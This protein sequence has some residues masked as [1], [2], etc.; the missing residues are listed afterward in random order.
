MEG[1]D[2]QLALV[3]L[4]TRNW[5]IRTPNESIFLHS[6]PSLWGKSNE[7]PG[8]APNYHPNSFHGPLEDK[9]VEPLPS[10]ASGPVA[11][12]ATKDEDNFGQ[13]AIFWAKVLNYV[14]FQGSHKAGTLLCCS[15][16]ER[17]LVEH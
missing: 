8:G 16:N 1:F 13:A 7:L 2:H 6:I 10:P 15:E 4:C 17:V 14:M 5:A 3:I 12:F 11:R 9:S